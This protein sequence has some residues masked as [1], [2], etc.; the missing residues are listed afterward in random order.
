M[1]VLQMRN[2]Y[3]LPLDSKKYENCSLKEL[4]GKLSEALDHLRE[5]KAVNEA[6]VYQYEEANAEWEELKRN[7]DQNRTDLKVRFLYHFL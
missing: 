1:N 4:D 6:A 7:F 2:V 5:Y 3:P